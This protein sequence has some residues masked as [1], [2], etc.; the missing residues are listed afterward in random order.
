MGIDEAPDQKCPRREVPL[1]PALS[2]RAGLRSFTPEF[3]SRFRHLGARARLKNED[4]PG[5]PPGLFRCQAAGCPGEVRTVALSSCWL[6]LIVVGGR[7]HPADSLLLRL[8][9][10]VRVDTDGAHTTKYHPEMSLHCA[11]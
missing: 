11:S 4:R 9:Q 10:A 7:W 8:W 1:T 2:P 6:R 3:L 5:C